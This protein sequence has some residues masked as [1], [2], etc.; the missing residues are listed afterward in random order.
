MQIASLHFYNHGHADL[1]IDRNP[2]LIQ[3]GQNINS[4]LTPNKPLSGK[5]KTALY[6]YA[7]YI[8]S[9]HPIKIVLRIKS[10]DD[11]MR[12]DVVGFLLEEF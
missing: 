10:Y 1:R 12:R 11:F 4:D 3:I 5:L 6:K 7:L 9:L 8:F 2:N